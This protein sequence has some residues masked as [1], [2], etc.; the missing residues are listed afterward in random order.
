M[1]VYVGTFYLYHHVNH[2]R[3]YSLHLCSSLNYLD[4]RKNINETRK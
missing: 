1:C 4:I 3:S 2:Y